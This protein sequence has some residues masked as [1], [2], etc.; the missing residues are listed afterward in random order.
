MEYK[1]A[2]KYFEELNIG[3][4]FITPGRTV[5]EA[6]LVSFSG[7]SG[8]YNPIHS[9]EEYTKTTAF[10][11]RIAHGPLTLSLATGLLFRV[12]A[13]DVNATAL[14]EL[15]SKY[16]H[17]VL[18]GDTISCVVEVVG[19]RESKKGQSILTLKYDVFNQ[20]KERVAEITQTEMY[21]RK[22]G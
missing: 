4:K 9:D 19:K 8:D 17:P 1:I 20:K 7:L 12:G 14:L 5:T 16:F 10:G 11:T 22:P 13:L 15:N 3:D 18:I 6:D 2:P 21:A